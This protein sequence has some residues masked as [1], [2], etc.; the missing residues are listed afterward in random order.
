MYLYQV[1]KFYPTRFYN[2]N[3]F[4]TFLIRLLISCHKDDYSQVNFGFTKL[5]GGDKDDEANKILNID[6]S[7]Y[8]FGSTKSFGDSSGDFYLIKV[9]NLGNIIFEKQFGDNANDVGINMIKTNNN[10]LLLVGTTTQGTDRNIKVINIDLDGNV[11][12]KITIGSSK[13]E[14]IGGVVETLNGEFCLCATQQQTN[15]YNKIYMVWINQNG[16]VVR[17]K[18]YSGNLT[19]GGMDVINVNSDLMVLAY[20]NSYGSGGQ[21][22]MLLKLNNQGDS[23]WAKTYGGSSYEESQEFVQLTNGNFVINGHSSSTDP[24]HDMFTVKTD[25]NGNQIWGLTIME[26]QN[27]TVEKLFY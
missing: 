23:I 10:N 19:D 20:T 3:I 13:D 26:V 17:E 15:G 9:D 27:M 1:N 5:Y 6:K 21:D 24:N 12:W 25:A 11:L 16:N 18:T 4:F 14:R 22:Y 8:I 7:I 2:E